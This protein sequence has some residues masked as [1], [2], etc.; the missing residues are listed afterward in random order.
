MGAEHVEHRPQGETPPATL[1]QAEVDA[2]MLDT[3]GHRLRP[4]RGEVGGAE[5]ALQLVI[6]I[7]AAG[8]WRVRRDG[9]GRVQGS[10]PGSPENPVGAGTDRI[11]A[12]I[13][14]ME[15]REKTPAEIFSYATIALSLAL[16]SGMALGHATEQSM[17]PRLATN[18]PADPVERFSLGQN[19][20]AMPRVNVRLTGNQPPAYGHASYEIGRYEKGARVLVPFEPARKIERLR[21]ERLQAWNDE[22]FG[23][24]AGLVDEPAEHAGAV[25]RPIDVGAVIDAP[26]APAAIP[27]I[28]LDGNGP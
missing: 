12:R 26:E 15:N 9:K 18:P 24:D 11:A 13:W 8:L 27:H 6:K 17:H 28:R 14:V 1:F 23:A 5:I 4:D 3:G 25:Y 21:L 2:H 7:H 22:S 16:L 19:A 10:L 20:F